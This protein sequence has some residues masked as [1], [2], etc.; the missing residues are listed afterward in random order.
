M[1][2]L[3][4]K[5]YWLIGASAGIGAAT[6]ELLAAAGAKLLLSARDADALEALRERL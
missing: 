2:E 6:A 5:R 3:A 4:N 1:P